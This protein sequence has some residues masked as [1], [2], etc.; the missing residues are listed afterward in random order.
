MNKT[1]KELVVVILIII[2]LQVTGLMAEVTG[3]VQRLILLTGLM[4]PDIE[5]LDNPKD[6][7]YDL[8]LVSMDGN[9]QSLHDFEGK[10][11]FINLW[12]TWCGPCIA[13]MPNINS[14]Y[15]KVKGEDVVF[16]M[17]NLDDEREK[18]YKFMERKG[19]G[20]PVY[21]P[22]KG[23]PSLYH[24]GTIPT[25]HVISPDGKII[26]TKTGTANYNTERFREFL[27]KQD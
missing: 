8:Q 21:F 9:H 27:E 23:V 18:A 19:F 15:N 10:T 14:L 2:V 3:A 16:V 1:I 11:I 24:S 25:T 5:Q 22:L 4:D 13:E 7:D 20:F 6:A 26:F 12:A 17:L